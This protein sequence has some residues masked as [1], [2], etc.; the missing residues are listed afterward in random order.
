MYLDI[1]LDIYRWYQK[2]R[3]ATA[4]FSAACD[5]E[6]VTMEAVC[7]TMPTTV[8]GAAAFVAFVRARLIE[9]EDPDDHEEIKVALATLE[10]SLTI[11]SGSPARSV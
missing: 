1:S 9:S 7:R 10:R 3:D 2:A 6:W 5:A 4:R 11:L 8:A